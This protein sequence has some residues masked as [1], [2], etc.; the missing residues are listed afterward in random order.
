MDPARLEA[1][2]AYVAAQKQ[3]VGA[4]AHAQ[5]EY[6]AAIQRHPD[7]DPADLADAGGMFGWD[8]DTAA[9]EVRL[10]GAMAMHEAGAAAG[11]AYQQVQPST[12]GEAVEQLASASIPTDR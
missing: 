3:A 7:I 9:D 11:D 4:K 2:I 6:A 10:A 8:F 12:I 1:A 5:N